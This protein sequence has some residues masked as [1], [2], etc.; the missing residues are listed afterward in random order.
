M[1]TRSEERD[2]QQ[3]I[4]Q[5]RHEICSIFGTAM[6]AIMVTEMSLYRMHC[7]MHAQPGLSPTAVV[8]GPTYRAEGLPRWKP[9]PL[10]PIPLSLMIV[11]HP[12][13]ILGILDEP[14]G[15]PSRVSA[16]RGTPPATSSHVLDVVCTITRVR[17]RWKQSVRQAHHHATKW[18]E[19]WET[20]NTDVPFGARRS[21]APGTAAPAPHPSAVA[22]LW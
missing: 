7:R 19:T 4:K 21:R 14:R 3:E 10:M 9:I 1:D 5:K 17:T 13:T 15:T 20:R 18:H 8:G 12:W 16:E 22:G 11:G 2:Q 6:S